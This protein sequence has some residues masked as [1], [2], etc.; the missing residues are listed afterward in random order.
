[1]EDAEF[2]QCDLFLEPLQN[3]PLQAVPFQGVTS[4]T[5]RMTT[6]SRF[7]IPVEKYT[8]VTAYRANKALPL[9]M[10]EQKKSY[11]RLNS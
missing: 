6:L 3:E 4:E 8:L 10:I 7:G 2:G 1:M 11:T 9:G 5:L